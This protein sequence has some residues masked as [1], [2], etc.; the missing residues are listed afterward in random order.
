MHSGLSQRYLP[1]DYRNVRDGQV[2]QSTDRVRLLSIGAYLLTTQ[3]GSRDALYPPDP[4]LG[5]Q[6]RDGR[7]GMPFVESCVLTAAE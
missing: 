2:F 6:R 7:S 5:S 1:G 3:S 4:I